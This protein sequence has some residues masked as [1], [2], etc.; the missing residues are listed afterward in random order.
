MAD[1]H[2]SGLSVLWGLKTPHNRTT[3][4]VPQDIRQQDSNRTARQRT[5][6]N[7]E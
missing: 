2:L 6:R 5:E 7:R 1:E 4:T 3:A